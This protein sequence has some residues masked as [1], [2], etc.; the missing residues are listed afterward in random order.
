MQ[1]SCYKLCKYSSVF[2]MHSRNRN[3]LLHSIL[4]KGKLGLKT[5]PLKTEEQ[6]WRAELVD[7]LVTRLAFIMG[8]ECLQSCLANPVGKNSLSRSGSVEIMIYKCSVCTEYSALSLKQ[9][10]ATVSFQQ[11]KDGRRV[12]TCFETR[13]LGQFQLLNFLLFWNTSRS[14]CICGIFLTSS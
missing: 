14:M 9:L 8:I 11:R 1:F 10:Y 12:E 5:E 6:V 13:T 4:E 7:K 2:G 3:G